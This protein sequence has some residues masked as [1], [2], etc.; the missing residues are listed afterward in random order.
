MRTAVTTGIIEIVWTNGTSVTSVT[1]GILGTNEIVGTAETTMGSLR[2][3]RP[4]G[5]L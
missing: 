4:Q 2:L 3:L 1:I 5:L